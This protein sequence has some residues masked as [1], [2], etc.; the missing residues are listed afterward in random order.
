MKSNKSKTESF[1]LPGQLTLWDIEITQKAEIITEK[2]SLYTETV[3]KLPNK[4]VSYTE[5]SPIVIS[6]KTE[7][8]INPLQLTDGQQDFLCKNNIYENENLNRVIKYCG[9]GL[10]IELQYEDSYKTIYVNTQ[11]K[12]EFTSERKMPVL[13]M[14][15]IMYYKSPFSEFNNIQEEKIKEVLQKYPSGKVIMRKADE[16]ILI[17]LQDKVISINPIGW[18]LEFQGCK[19][20]YKEDEVE[21]QDPSEEVPIEDI[22]KSIKLG[23]IIEAQHGQRIIN[24]EIVRVYGPGNVTLNIV[25]DNGTK[26]T[27]VHR[28]KV[29]KLIKCA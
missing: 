22:Q 7:K 3:D 20:V 6:P 13:P 17:E 27:A 26:H 11:G 8:P 19:A 2:P 21:R 28:S 14:D 16:N 9:G 18:V 4:E 24:G 1:M 5:L 23:D 29:T 12:E 15:K 10:G 25:F